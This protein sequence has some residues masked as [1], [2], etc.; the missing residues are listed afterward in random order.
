MSILA[1]SNVQ[2]RPATIRKMKPQSLM[3]NEQFAGYVPADQLLSP[4]QGIPSSN[5]C[6][7]LNAHMV[8]GFSQFNSNGQLGTNDDA[9]AFSVHND[10]TVSYPFKIHTGS[11]SDAMPIMAWG[12]NAGS[13]IS[14]D[15][16]DSFSLEN[17]SHADKIL[18]QSLQMPSTKSAF[19]TPASNSSTPKYLQ[20]E[21]RQ[22]AV[23]NSTSLPPPPPPRFTLPVKA[24]YNDLPS[25]D[26]PPPPPELLFPDDSASGVS[27]DQV[28]HEQPPIASSMLSLNVSEI[29]LKSH[30]DHRVLNRSQSNP[31]AIMSAANS[32][33]L[34]MECLYPYPPVPAPVTTINFNNNGNSS[35]GLMT[36]VRN[37]SDAAAKKKPE[38]QSFTRTSSVS[39]I[40]ASLESTTISN[41]SENLSK[42]P[43]I[44]PNKPTRH[45][46][47]SY[48]QGNCASQQSINGLAWGR[49]D[50]CDN[51][52][53]DVQMFQGVH[54]QNPLFQDTR[55]TVSSVRF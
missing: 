24:C 42:K 31:S 38:I 19:K 48:Q 34:S 20:K 51:E 11:N 44:I 18:A 35:N 9:F 43:P 54:S 52:D 7:Q 13:P 6:P 49:G 26:L 8:G 17:M 55:F 53:D 15:A 10:K 30:S 37:G 22:A 16:A 33:S 27:T 5:T 14:G 3:Y 32:L 21:V 46:I 47:I 12:R 45:S 40:A 2:L 23:A 1:S 29:P 39:N 50:S 36:L 4:V 25:P 28:I 41:R